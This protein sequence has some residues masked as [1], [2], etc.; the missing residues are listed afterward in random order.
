MSKELKI[1]RLMHTKCND[2]Y[3]DLDYLV[4]LQ[5]GADLSDDN[6]CDL[7]DNTGDNI[8][9]FNKIYL[10]TTGHYWVWKNAKKSK[11]VGFEHYRRHIKL[12]KD[13]ILHSLEN[14][15]IITLKPIT[16]GSVEKQYEFCHSAYDLNTIKQIVLDLYPEYTQSWVTYITKGKILIPC[17]SFITKWEIF[18]DMWSFI[19]NILDEFKKRLNLKTI[20]DYKNH[21]INTANKICPLTHSNNGLT[22]EE[23][24]MR[25]FGS[26]TERLITLYIL[27]NIPLDKIGFAEYIEDEAKPS[28]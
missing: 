11:Y 14:L 6:V 18:D 13:A 5:V 8:S 3:K 27:H 19:T 4:N 9:L 20:E 12:G 2:I 7:K 1:Y 25:I 17:N 16:V 10:E 15:D 28:I 22:W 26:L 23:Y 24:Q 21:V